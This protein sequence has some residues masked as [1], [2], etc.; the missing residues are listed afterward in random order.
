MEFAYSIDRLLELLGSGVE[1]KGAY[2]G[3]VRGLASLDRAREGDLSFLGNPKYRDRVASSEA[4]VLLLPRD[5]PGPPRDN[6]L[7]LRVENPSLALALVCRDIEA[8]LF[9]SPEP[10]VHPSAVV[11]S[12]AKIAEAASVGPFCHIRAGAE[13]GVCVLESHVSV[14]RFAEVGD[15][16]RLFPHSVVGDYCELGERNRVMAGCVIGSDG[17]GYEFRDGAHERVP[18]VGNVVTEADVDIGANTTVD[19]ARFESTRIGRGTKIDNLVQI[20][21]NV[22]IGAHC[23]VVAQVGISGSTEL[24]DGVVAAGQAGIAGHL[25]I[26]EGARIAGGAA[27]TRSV[28]PGESVRGDPAEPMMLFN[29]IAVLR[30]RLPEILKRLDQLEKNVASA[31]TIP[32]N[33]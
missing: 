20:A 19:R 28:G 9:P 7:Q 16:C 10:G 27:V 4:S 12:G 22:R 18:Q 15:G 30:R 6:Q 29:R 17:Y 14:G 1:M 21:H 2:A 3:P 24:A 11:E 25:R 8:R 23:L 33:P 31:D 26:G 13:I 5:F 32:D